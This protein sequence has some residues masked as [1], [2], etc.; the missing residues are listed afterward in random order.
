MLPRLAFFCLVSSGTLLAQEPVLHWSAGEKPREFSRADEVVLVEA[1]GRLDDAK[2]ASLEAWVFPRRA[3]EQT[4]AGRGLPTIGPGGERFFRRTE[5]W[6]NYFVGTDA[7]GFLMG[8][9]NGN[10]RMP[11]PLVTLE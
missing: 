5:G 11:F 4:I 10:S 6:T 9:I 1:A 8:C 3:G 2:G 7:H